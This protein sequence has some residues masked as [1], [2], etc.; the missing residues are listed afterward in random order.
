MSSFLN[1]LPKT[2]PAI[3][4]CLRKVITYYYTQNKIERFNAPVDDLNELRKLVAEKF[5]I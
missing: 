1:P 5:K 3:D 4:V 2:E